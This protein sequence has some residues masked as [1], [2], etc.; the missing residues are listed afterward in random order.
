MEPKDAYICYNRADL[1]WVARLA[2][3]IESETI[4]GR[5]DGRR[6]AAFFD[7]WDIDP[8]QSLIDQM[9]TGMAAARHVITVLSPEF[10]KADWP[11]F[12]WKHVV[13]ADPNNTKGK[14]IPVLFRNTTIDGKER[15]NYP[16]PF[17]D[18]KYI[19]FRKPSDFKR[20][21][22]ELIRRISKPPARER[23]SAETFGRNTSDLASSS[24]SRGV[25]AT[26]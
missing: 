14:I 1:S 8:G 10:L 22:N 11:R 12:E 19:D 26:G 25:V 21:F 23:T 6:L 9:N 2:E 18:L 15:I 16:A 13:A 7:K 17:L 24:S 3:Q 20:S 5:D 4:D